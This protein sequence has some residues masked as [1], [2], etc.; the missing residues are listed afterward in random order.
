M[1]LQQLISF[2]A[3]C[4]LV[5]VS[6][7]TLISQ[8]KRFPERYDLRD[9]QE[10]EILREEIMQEKDPAKRKQLMR[11]YYESDHRIAA[12]PDFLKLQEGG[13]GL[14]DSRRPIDFFEACHYLLAVFVGDK[15]QGIANHVD[16]TQLNEH[17]FSS[18]PILTG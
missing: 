1:K 15:S 3:L 12:V 9:R 10:L 14:F 2:A 16:D 18:D 7:E 5:V 13:F 17:P 6:Q 11:E 4:F 8:S